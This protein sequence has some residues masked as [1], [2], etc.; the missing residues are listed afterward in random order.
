MPLAMDRRSELLR[1]RQAVILA[2][3]RGTRLGAI[4][5]SIPKPMVPFHGRPFL[6]YLIEFLRDQGMKKFLLLLGY[7]PE[8]VREYFGD[9]RRLGVEIEYSVTPVE[10]DTGTRLRKAI[11]KIEP[12]FLLAY[13]D[14]Y[15]RST[16]RRC[17]G[18]SRAATR[19][20]WS[21]S[22]PT[23]TATHATMS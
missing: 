9:G 14:N 1:P 3:G 5:E 21:P 19:R 16:S 23:T 10:D 4:T 22:M 8:T 12:T 18:V 6:E 13:C 15:C 20:R 11:P 17:G 2:G 7:L